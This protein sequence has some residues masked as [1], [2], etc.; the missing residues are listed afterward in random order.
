MSRVPVAVLI[1]KSDIEV[2]NREIGW[3][4]INELFNQNP[5]AYNNKLDIARDQI[6]KEYMLKIGLVNVM[7][8]IEATFSNVSFFPVSAIGHIAE[9][10]VAYTPVGVINP[11][12]WIAK[13]SRSKIARFFLNAR[14]ELDVCKNKV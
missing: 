5:A 2:V 1:N 10:G 3:D 7:N 9:D 12:A 14:D 13:E 6:C 4:A 8:N 11:V